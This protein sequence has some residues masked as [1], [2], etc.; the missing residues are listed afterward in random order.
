MSRIVNL[1]GEPTS[2]KWPEGVRLASACHM[3][4]PR[5]NPCSF[6]DVL[7]LDNLSSS[8]RAAA[9]QLTECML[10]LD[11][12]KRPSA[13]QSLQS[14]FFARFDPSDQAT[15][16][17]SRV[18]SA[19]R[20]SKRRESKEDDGMAS[21]SGS[22]GG[23]GGRSGSGGGS[24]SRGGSG[25]RSSHVSRGVSQGGVSQG[26]ASETPSSPSV[27]IED[28]IDDLLGDLGFP[29]SPAPPHNSSK[30]V[31]SSLP[32][33]KAVDKVSTQ[34][35]AKKQ[36]SLDEILCSLDA[37]FQHSPNEPTESTEGDDVGADFDTLSPVAQ[38][39]IPSITHPSPPTPTP[40]FT[41]SSPSPILHAS[42]S[43]SPFVSSPDVTDSKASE[44]K[45]SASAKKSH[46]QSLPFSEQELA[47]L[48][49][50]VEL[51]PI[52]AGLDRNVRWKKIAHHVGN[53]RSKKECFEAFRDHCVS[54]KEKKKKKESRSASNESIASLP[55]EETEESNAS[56]EAA[57]PVKLREA[58]SMRR[59]EQFAPP[60]VR[61]AEAPLVVESFDDFN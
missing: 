49:S 47:I 25:G 60:A 32:Q 8:E 11:P 22:R 3:R 51:F 4:I 57:V 53:G 18:T 55:A 33:I 19:D 26:G 28:D 13:S 7:K 30:S 54:A 12:S 2:S 43:P 24:G 14:N 20:G 61:P 5:T 50:A 45:S 10:D 27:G 52:S 59:S 16:V 6:T 48:V 42:P 56:Q 29:I 40:I 1:V 37:E 58:R 41:Q 17:Q 9:L 46:T 39:H 36:S 44:S 23:S 35:F 15:E 31:N 38:E 34:S 21:G